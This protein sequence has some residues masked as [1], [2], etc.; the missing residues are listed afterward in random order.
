[1]SLECLISG[2]L[3]EFL[4]SQQVKSRP[5]HILAELWKRI[6]GSIWRGKRLVGG[7]RE[8]VKNAGAILRMVVNRS[9]ILDLPALG[10]G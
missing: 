10:A 1:M 6:L 2:G 4:A 9:Q 5:G 3:E 7:A 8:M